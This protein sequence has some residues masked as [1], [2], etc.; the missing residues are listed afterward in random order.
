[1]GIQGPRKGEGSGVSRASEGVLLLSPRPG[2]EGQVLTDRHVV[3]TVRETGVPITELGLVAAAGTLGLTGHWVRHGC[4]GGRLMSEGSLAAPPGSPHP[5]RLSL[6]RAGWAGPPGRPLR[7]HHCAPFPSATSEHR[8][9]SLSHC[10]CLLHFWLSWGWGAPPSR[11]G[12]GGRHM[13]AGPR[14]AAARLGLGCWVPAFRG[15]SGVQ[16]GAVCLQSQGAQGREAARF[17]GLE[18][19]PVHP[20]VPPFPFTLS[21]ISNCI[22]LALR[23]WRWGR[24]RWQR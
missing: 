21:C 19:L 5:C 15:L 22:L 9:P 23:R 18:G 10:S 16:A 7:G 13:W 11:L 8:H 17:R 20:A 12:K 14:R 2:G 24:Q 3:A 4:G 1:M 6:C